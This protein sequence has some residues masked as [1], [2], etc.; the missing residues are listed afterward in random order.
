MTS[1]L[2]VITP[3]NLAGLR[4][5]KAIERPPFINMLVYGNSGVGKTRLGGSADAVPQMRKVLIIDI[6]GGTLTLSHSYR[7]VDIVRVETWAQM[8][9]VY[10]ELLT[11]N[12]GYN[13]VVVDSLTEIQK[14][15]MYDIMTGLK[16]KNPDRDEDVP[17]MREW[18]INLEQMRKFVRAFRDAP[19]NVIFTALSKEEKNARTGII[20]KMPSLSGK[21]A[22]EVAAFLDIVCYMYKKEVNGDLQHMILTTSTEEFIAKD[23]TGKLPLVIQNPTMTEIYKHIQSDTY[24]EQNNPLNVTDTTNTKETINA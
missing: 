9:A 12:T 3:R 14:F 22:G 11:G 7:N 19:F 6:E 8:Q 16:K 5:V 1:S 2:D 24:Q 18:G 15:N 17:S 21:L 4:V 13:T 10:D 23:R 20:H